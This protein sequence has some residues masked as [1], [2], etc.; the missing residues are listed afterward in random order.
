MTILETVIKIACPACGGQHDGSAGPGRRT[1]AYN[2]ASR[3]RVVQQGPPGPEVVGRAPHRLEWSHFERKES[4]RNTRCAGSFDS[5]VQYLAGLSSRVLP[6]GDK[7][8]A[9]YLSS[10]TYGDGRSADANAEA[11]SLVVLDCDSAGDWHQLRRWFV[12]VG[13][14]GMFQFSTSRKGWHIAIPLTEPIRFTKGSNEERTR[15]KHEYKH[16]VAVFSALAGFAGVGGHC[17]LDPCT[18]RLVQPMFVPMRK[19]E[20]QAPAGIEYVRGGAL[21]WRALLTATGFDYGVSIA[22]DNKTR[23]GGRKRAKRYVSF[24]AAPVNPARFGPMGQA[25][26]TA[27]MLGRQKDADGYHAEC[28]SPELHSNGNPHGYA[29]YYPSTD[30]LWCASSG[31]KVKSLYKTPAKLVAKLPQSAQDVYWG[32]VGKP[33]VT[34]P[35]AARVSEVPAIQAWLDKEAELH[36]SL[37]KPKLIQS[38]VGFL[39]GERFARPTLEKI[40]RTV[41]DELGARDMVGKSLLYKSDGNKLKGVGGLRWL[42][43]WAM[44]DL[45]AAIN[46]DTGHSRFD[47]SKKLVSFATLRGDPGRWLDELAN[48]MPADESVLSRQIRRPAHCMKYIEFVMGDGD[49]V[50]KRHLV[51]E[52]KGCTYCWH[53]RCVAEIEVLVQE[54]A[55]EKG[56][57]FHTVTCPDDETLHKFDKVAGKQLH[58][59]RVKIHGRHRDGRPTL[60][61]VTNCGKSDSNMRGAFKAMSKKTF[62]EAV[63][64]TAKC[65]ELGPALSIIYRTRMSLWAHQRDFLNK[66][67]DEGLVDWVKFLRP[68]RESGLRGA[69][70]LVTRGR[71]EGNLYWPNRKRLRE[72]MKAKK[73]GD[74]P[75]IDL[76]DFLDV[77]FVLA[78]ATT[79]TEFHVQDYPHQL[80]AA[81]KIAMNSPILKDA[82]ESAN[83]ETPY[84]DLAH[85]EEQLEK[86]PSAR[87]PVMS[88]EEAGELCRAQHHPRE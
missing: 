85:R 54:W 4:Q 45:A 80:D 8:L 28:P 81:A 82:K 49:L 74:A 33:V 43:P 66:R 44:L 7:K 19:D 38:L 53:K 56:F 23:G 25:L 61:W 78:D 42:G 73:K 32:I 88:W 83:R 84:E 10:V 48:R 21:N 65:D 36:P 27:G 62:P 57:Y 59:P 34:F 47:L 79:G 18:D 26:V 40:A 24:T 35:R 77:A 50:M 87:L 9:P 15:F 37:D 69:R 6:G 11:I 67:D 13:L 72:H 1:W 41:T 76:D 14:A 22:A 64:H 70:Q 30:I 60:T 51:C 3:A 2:E 71:S 86:R 12:S 58:F 20:A 46:A 39:I 75:E 31:C 16:V 29:I 5:Y 68:L 63:W 17:G 52:D 55:G